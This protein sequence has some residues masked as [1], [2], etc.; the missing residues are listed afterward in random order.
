MDIEHIDRVVAG[1]R[2]K[3]DRGAVHG[4]DQGELFG[5]TLPKSLLVVGRRGPG[6]ALAFLVIV[7]GQFL[8]AGAEDLGEQRRVGDQERPQ[9]EGRMRAGHHVFLG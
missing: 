4:G 2:G 6:L 8:D 1:E 7:G 3:A 9:R 5:E